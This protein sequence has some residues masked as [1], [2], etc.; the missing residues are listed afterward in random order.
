MIG[1]LVQLIILFFVIIDPFASFVVFLTATKSMTEKEKKHI[2]FYAIVVAVGLSFLVLLLGNA[3]L[4]LFSTTLDE[5]RIA[6]GIVLCILG[7]KMVLGKSIT[8][9]NLKDRSGRAI[10]SI[11]GTPLLT[12]PAAIT[13]ILV[14]TADYGRIVTGIALA[15][16]LLLTA[17]L[18]LRAYKVGKV[19]GFTGIQVL[20]TLLGLIT[21]AWGVKF[22]TI[23]VQNIFLI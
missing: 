10:A 14:S 7:I 9:E 22:I 3:L 23:G 16:V 6:G 12:G 18:F 5:F 15:V 19:L 2:A 21:L 8:D 11:I 13:A 4:E 1:I 20:S 17:L